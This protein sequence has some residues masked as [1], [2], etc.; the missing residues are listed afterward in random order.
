MPGKTACV[1]DQDLD[2]AQR[3]CRFIGESLRCALRHDVGLDAHRCRSTRSDDLARELFQERYA[4]RSD[5]AAHAFSRE[6]LGNGA[7]DAHACP[8]H[9]RRLA[10]QL[11]I[12]IEPPL[13]I[14]GFSRRPRFSTR[15]TACAAA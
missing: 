5:R 3:L 9:E 12:H 8:G 2:A 10:L 7:P 1:I 4:P 13:V 6:L 11:Q 15:S 14:K